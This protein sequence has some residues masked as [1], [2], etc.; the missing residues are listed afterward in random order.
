MTAPQGPTIGLMLPAIANTDTNL[1]DPPRVLAAAR[2]AEEAGFDGVYVGDHLLHPRGLLEA[3]V[4]LSAVAATTTRV[5][6]GTCVMLVALR[7][8]LWLAKQLGTLAAFAPGRLRI[9]IGLGGEYPAEFAA[10]G[11]PLAE[12]GRRAE[13]VLAEVRDLLAGR[14]RPTPGADGMD[15]GI[16]PVPGT[17]VPILLAG[18][19]E[20]A[21]RRAA[22]IGDGWIG[23]LLSPDSFTRRRDQL[24]QYRAEEGGKPFITGML[25]PVHPD[26]G[27][28]AHAQ[29]G[30]AWKR[31]TGAHATFPERLFVAGSPDAI[32]EQLHAYWERGCTEMVLSLVDMGEPFVKQLD[33]LCD[34]VLPEVRAFKN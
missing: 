23:Y 30:A 31:L 20:V 7:D 33:M 27:S 6:I 10:A 4:T 28:D 18:W 5:S 21:L 32:V 2:L 8:P 17:D 14:T 11:V 34:Q 3:V 1:V 15:V 13:E 29:A 24:L 19:K 25:L 16:D 26:E 9:G 22:R 12:R